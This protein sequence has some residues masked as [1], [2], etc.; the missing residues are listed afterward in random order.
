LYRNGGRE[1]GRQGVREKVKNEVP[2]RTQRT[3]AEALRNDGAGKT[4]EK[5]KGA[6]HLKVAPTKKRDA[7]CG[8]PL[9]IAVKKLS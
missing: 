4:E 3:D 5:S 8:V 1:T 9:M 6:A 2:Q 7:G